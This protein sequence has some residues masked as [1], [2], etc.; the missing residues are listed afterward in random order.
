MSALPDSSGEGSGSL[1]VM[2]LNE[3]S[4]SSTGLS[5]LVA[6]WS[7][8]WG[9]L[10]GFSCAD[11]S[12]GCGWGNWGSVLALSCSLPP[13]SWLM[14]IAGGDAP[15]SDVIICDCVQ[16]KRELPTDPYM[17]ACTM[18]YTVPLQCYIYSYNPLH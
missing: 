5:L 8:V 15:T 3:R 14:S 4:V 11:W 1:A 9:L 12:Q 18:T 2:P 16:Q 6:A 17:H 7:L 13:L 10:V